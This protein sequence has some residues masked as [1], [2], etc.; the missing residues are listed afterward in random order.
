MANIS[1]FILSLLASLLLVLAVPLPNNVELNKRD[2]WG[3]GTWFNVGE[4]AC[5]DWNQNSDSIVAISSDIYGDGGS[6]NQWVE[7][8]NTQTGASAWGQIRD[9][10]PSC[11]SGSLDMSPGLFQKLGDLSTGVLQIQWNFS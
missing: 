1:L 6:C 4:G 10:C 9:E 3:Q 11:D 5:G 7:V 8:T 2:Y